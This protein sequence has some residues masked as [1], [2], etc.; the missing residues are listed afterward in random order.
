MF[1]EIGIPED[2]AL[3][4][5]ELFVFNEIEDSLFH[6]VYTYS[7]SAVNF[8]QLDHEMLKEIG[9][10]TLGDRLKILNKLKKLEN[11]LSDIKILHIIGGGNFGRYL[12][13]D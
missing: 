4:Y 1:I 6:Q 12:A 13:V 11:T 5:A 2:R 3:K 7:C 9:V 10:T 8:Y